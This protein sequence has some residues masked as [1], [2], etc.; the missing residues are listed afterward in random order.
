MPARRIAAAPDPAPSAAET[1]TVPAPPPVELWSAAARRLWLRLALVGCLAAAPLVLPRHAAAAD[2]PCGTFIIDDVRGYGVS[3]LTFNPNGHIDVLYTHTQSY[4]LR[5][6]CLLAILCHPDPPPLVCIEEPE[7]G[8]HPDV[9]PTLAELLLD[10]SARSQVIVTTHSDVLVDALTETPEGV[11]V[12]EKRRGQTE[13]QRLEKDALE[14][15]LDRYSLGELW[16]KGE[17]GGNR[18]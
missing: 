17:L 6:L 12:C 9:L 7:L 1:K 2:F 3:T 8:L 4:T 13:I 15:W 16:R 5:F 10:A 11:V 18:W 14:E